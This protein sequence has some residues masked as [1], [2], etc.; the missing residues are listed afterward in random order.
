[1]IL[2]VIVA[3]IFVQISSGKLIRR[4]LDTRAATEAR[5][6]DKGQV[7][8]INEDEPTHDSVDNASGTDANAGGS[9]A[10]NLAVPTTLKVN[11]PQ[12]GAENGVFHFNSRGPG[13]Y[14]AFAF[15]QV[16]P[17]QQAPIV[18]IP[19]ST[20]QHY[21]NPHMGASISEG[22]TPEP[23]PTFEA[24][25]YYPLVW[26]FPFSNIQLPA[27]TTTGHYAYTANAVKY[28]GTLPSQ[29]AEKVQEVNEAASRGR[30]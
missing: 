6:G 1:M 19:L 11:S 21:Y 22:S 26:R 13:K 12:A 29:T 17:V 4:G 30:L 9:L 14:I 15:Q 18:G 20:I 23:I 27:Y 25:A 3:L 8:L 10:G 16:A 7:D 2:R 24:T 28:Y 5:L